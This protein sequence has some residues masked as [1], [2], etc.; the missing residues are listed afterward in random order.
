M[1]MLQSRMRIRFGLFFVLTLLCVLFLLLPVLVCNCFLIAVVC[2]EFVVIA[3]FYL[4]FIILITFGQSSVF[5]LYVIPV[6]SYIFI[7]VWGFQLSWRGVHLTNGMETL[8]LSLANCFCY[9]CRKR[10]CVG[11]FKI[12]GYLK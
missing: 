9:S 8:N 12:S 7:S 3:L 11:V 1:A 5:L 6:L 4:N 10:T 2:L